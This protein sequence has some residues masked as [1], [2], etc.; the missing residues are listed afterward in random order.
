MAKTD[1]PEPVKEQTD[2][3]NPTTAK[4]EKPLPSEPISER[5]GKSAKGTSEP[6]RKSVRQELKEI[7]EA[8]FLI[9]F[10]QH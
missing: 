5:S 4:T 7:C 10:P 2:N 1:Q 8:R 9:A 6:E 3:P